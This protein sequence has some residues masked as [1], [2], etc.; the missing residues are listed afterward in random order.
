MD[1]LRDERVRS[2][3]EAEMAR[4]GGVYKRSTAGGSSTGS[5]KSSPKIIDV[6]IVE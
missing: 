5:R 6:E 2:S 1:P 4:T 3:L